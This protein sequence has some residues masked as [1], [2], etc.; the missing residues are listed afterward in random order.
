ML[1]T[2]RANLI[3]LMFEPGG[4]RVVTIGTA[5]A[6]LVHLA[7]KKRSMYVDLV[8]NLPIG[9]IQQGRQQRVSVVIVEVVAR[10]E[11][12][13]H[14][15]LASRMASRA[16]VDLWSSLIAFEPRESVTTLDRKSVV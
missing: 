10:S 9:V 3:A 7:L 14:A 11:A 12:W 6:L 15:P 8:L 13:M 2:R 16:H 1:M 4:M 5:N